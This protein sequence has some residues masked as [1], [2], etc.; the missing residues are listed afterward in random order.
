[1][2][3]ALQ[4]GVDGRQNKNLDYVYVCRYCKGNSKV[5][6]KFKAHLRLRKKKVVVTKSVKGEKPRYDQNFIRN[7]DLICKGNQLSTA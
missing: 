1:M 7:I 3:G 2:R 6:L 5:K 4:S